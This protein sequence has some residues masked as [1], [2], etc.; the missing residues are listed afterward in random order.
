MKITP[1]TIDDFN[2][3]ALEIRRK[4]SKEV[5]RALDAEA[6]VLP[7]AVRQFESTEFEFF[8][9]CM[10]AKR[11]QLLKML[12]KRGLSVSDLAIRMDRDP[13][14]IRKDVAAL[15]SLGLIQSTTVL[16]AGH[17]LK[18]IIRPVASR[19]EVRGVF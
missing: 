16:N 18:K 3:P 10:S 1:I 15:A 14:V 17:G 6:D 11:F 19:I 4:R 5:A 7:Y 2:I 13:S 9:R 8:L 12:P